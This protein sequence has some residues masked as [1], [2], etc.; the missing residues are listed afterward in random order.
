VSFVADSSNA[1]SRRAQAEADV[2]RAEIAYRDAYATLTTL[3][4]GK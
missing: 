1:P 4:A 3:I 2:F